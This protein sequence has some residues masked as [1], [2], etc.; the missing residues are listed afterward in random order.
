MDHAARRERNKTVFLAML[1]ALGRK[2]W[3]TGFGLMTADVLC[4]WPYK[5]IPAMDAE[6]RGRD[7]I[8]AF[9]AFGQDAFE[10]LNYRIDAIHELLDPDSIIAE[11]RSDSR[12]L[13]SGLPSGDPAFSRWM[14]VLLA[15]IHQ[16]ANDNGAV[17][18][19]CCGRPQALSAA[20]T[21]KMLS[22]RLCPQVRPFHCQPA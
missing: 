6:M 7:T 5:P 15:R 13:A 14:C 8:R 12:H 2:D 21:L 18:R 16:S 10:G 20:D 1:E 3:D 9:F 22:L 19:H 4:D 17:R 11:Y